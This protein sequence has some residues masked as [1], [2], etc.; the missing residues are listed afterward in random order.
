MSSDPMTPAPESGPKQRSWRF[1]PLLRYMLFRAGA[2]LLLLVGVTMVTFA[3]ANIV[4]GDPA[5]AALGE[6]AAADPAIVAAYRQQAGLDQPLHVQ[7]SRYL[8]RLV[9]GDLGTSIQ[10]RLPVRQELGRAF[11]ATIE[12]AVSSILVS[13]V[14]AT[15]LGLWA[16]MRRGRTVDQVIRTLSLVGLSVPIFWLAMVAYYVLFYKARIFPGSGRLAPTLSPPPEVTGLYTVD[17]LLAGQWQ[18]LLNAAQHLVL[19]A[20]VLGL[21]TIGLLTRFIRSAVLEV[22]AQDYVL[23]ARA[24]GLPSHVIIRD[25]V[26]R[27]AALPI[28]T[29]VG[30]AFGALLSGTVLVEKIFAWHGLGEYA[31]SAATHLDI[32]AIMAVGVTVGAVYIGINFVVDLLYGVLDPRVRVS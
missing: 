17:A 22:L 2:S 13:V 5:A 27:G 26:L 8:G 32:P 29:V 1:P 12:L 9:Q 4:P 20:G 11:P 16:A 25:Y 28:I 23:A 10:T 15:I 21:Y 6:Q 19:P 7:Y 30:L 18:T 3:L 24:K 31:F 14:L